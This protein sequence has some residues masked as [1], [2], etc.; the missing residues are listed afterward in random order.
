MANSPKNR[1]LGNLHKA[2]GEAISMWAT[3]ELQLHQLFSISLTLVAM[4]PGG[5]FS[6]DNTVTSS[7]LDSIDGFRGKL[8]MIDAALAGALG[9]LDAEADQLLNDW[10]VERKKINNLHGNRNALAHWRALRI[11]NADGSIKKFVIQSPTLKGAGGEGATETDVQCWANSFREAANR[12][13][14]LV[15]RLASHRG[16]QRTHLE[17]A[18]S[19]IQCCLPDDPTL[20]EFLKHE[21]TEH[22][23]P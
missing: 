19:Q 5:G 1:D 3:I 22:L 10:A 17:R 2:V 9:G 11:V 14:G 18:A 20:L 23:K 13:A 15:T 21:L 6:Y 12:L 8:L 16:L 4:Q 7:V